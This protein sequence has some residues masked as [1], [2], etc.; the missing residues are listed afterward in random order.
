[1]DT[2]KDFIYSRK[3]KLLFI[4]LFIFYTARALL[5]GSYSSEHLINFIPDD[6]F[7]YLNMVKHKINDGFWSFDGSNPA[8]GFHILFAYL[9]TA[10]ANLASPENWLTIFKINTAISILF[11]STACTIIYKTIRWYF[12]EKASVAALAVFTTPVMLIQPT[13]IMESS[14]VILLASLS[15]C[16]ILNPKIKSRYLSIKIALISLGILTSLARSDAA[17]TIGCIFLVSFTFCILDKKNSLEEI[18][19]KALWALSGT[20]IGLALSFTHNYFVSGH[21]LQ[22]SAHVKSFWSQ[23]I[24]YNLEPSARLAGLTILPIAQKSSLAFQ[25][26]ILTLISLSLLLFIKNN[27]FSNKNL[28]TFIGIFSFFGYLF[29]YG[30]NSQSIQYWYISNFSIPAVFLLASIIE[31]IPHKLKSIFLYV[32]IIFSIG[33]CLKNYTK[34][35]YKNQQGMYLLAKNHMPPQTQNN[36]VYASWNAGILGYFSKTGLINIDGLANDSIVEY[37]TSGNLYQ[38]LINNKITHIVDYESMFTNQEL[39][40]RGGYDEKISDCLTL[41]YEDTE[42]DRNWMNTNI[43]IYD[44]DQLCLKDLLNKD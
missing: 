40:V 25:I 7:Y 10:I 1:L 42:I 30:A 23:I 36:R 2:L 18:R 31:S 3:T 38:Y 44:V 24:G 5:I 8:T 11:L 29:F 43:G 26:P 33:S 27:K 6:A 21:I 37:I 9:L 19:T 16:T 32:I 15:S 12:S 35:I 41:E 17:L 14:L 28:I 4:F 13:M 20:I 34:P 22:S 39:I